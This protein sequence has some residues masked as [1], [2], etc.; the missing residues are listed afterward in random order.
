MRCL[1]TYTQSSCNSELFRIQQR[2][3]PKLGLYNLVYTGQL[4]AESGSLVDYNNR[5]KNQW[6]KISGGY[7]GDMLLVWWLKTLDLERGSE[8]WNCI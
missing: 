8:F 7:S 4:I 2:V 1:P 3:P 6:S 5:I